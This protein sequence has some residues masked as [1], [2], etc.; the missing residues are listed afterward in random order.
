LE[1]IGADG[2]ITL[3]WIQKWDEGSDLIG[4]AQYWDRWR[5]VLKAVINIL[6]L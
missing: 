6:D 3:K 5:D 4:L 1:I 2:R